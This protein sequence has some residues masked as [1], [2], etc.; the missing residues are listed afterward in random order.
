MR[1]RDAYVPFALPI[2]TRDI[3][4]WPGATI[5]LLM[6]FIPDAILVAI[7]SWAGN[8]LPLRLF[9]Q[10]HWPGTGGGDLVQ[11]VEQECQGPLLEAEG[12][13]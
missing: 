2:R 4:G 6:A 13:L 11:G 8:M 7:V 10:P 3:I 1:P 5:P 12:L 9:P